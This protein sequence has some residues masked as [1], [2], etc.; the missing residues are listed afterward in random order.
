M[1]MTEMMN[2]LRDE[3]DRSEAGQQL[4]AKAAKLTHSIDKIN[5][6][7]ADLNKRK[8]AMKREAD[9]LAYQRKSEQNDYI[10]E[11]LAK[12]AE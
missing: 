2:M 4:S 9:K 1:N 6:E 10:V 7:L 8:R 5:T 11:Q 3:F 12:R